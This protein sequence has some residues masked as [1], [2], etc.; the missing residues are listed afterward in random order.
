MSLRS[1]MPGGGI[2]SL[3]CWGIADSSNEDEE[4][5]EPILCVSKRDEFSSD[6]I[7]YYQHH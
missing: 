3:T 1:S 7:Y 4:G 5:V 2:A 6:V